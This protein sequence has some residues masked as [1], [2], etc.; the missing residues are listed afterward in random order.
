MGHILLLNAGNIQAQGTYD[1]LIQ[2]GIDFAQL[3]N[4]EDD[5][6]G[7]SPAMSPL[8]RSSF[9]RSRTISEASVHSSNSYHSKGRSGS[10]TMTGL[11]GTLKLMGGIAFQCLL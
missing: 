11:E 2:S 3:L 4:T 1:D 5:K 10:L 6:D 8:K 9:G 7:A